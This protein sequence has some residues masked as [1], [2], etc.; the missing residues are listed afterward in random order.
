[1]LGRGLVRGSS[2]V[3]IATPAAA[4]TSHHEAI[5]GVREV[6]EQLARIVVVD[7]GSHGNRC[8]DRFSFAPA[9]IAPFAV[10]PALSRV[11][12]IKPEMQ[13]GVVVLAGDQNDV[14]PAPAVAAARPA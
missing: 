1:M 13:Q 4:A 10:T 11:L 2:K 9:T 8:F 5:A 3:L 7:Y 12:R 14:T 6:V